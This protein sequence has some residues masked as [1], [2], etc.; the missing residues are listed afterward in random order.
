MA[1][2][3]PTMPASLMPGQTTRGDA[4]DER[5]VGPEE[6]PKAVSL[7]EGTHQYYRQPDGR[8]KLALIG[9]LRDG[10]GTAERAYR[11]R[12]WEPL[13]QYGRY[14]FGDWQ[15]EHPL[16]NLFIAG[17]ARELTLAQIRE[18][19]WD[20]TPPTIPW[21]NLPE[22]AEHKAK[23]RSTLHT[24]GCFE[25]THAVVF[26]QLAG[27]TP[28]TV[29][30]CDFCERDDIPTAAARKQHMY[31]MHKDELAQVRMGERIATVLSQSTQ[32][33]M[34]ADPFGCQVCGEGFSSARKLT[35][36]VRKHQEQNA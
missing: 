24:D 3:T 9:K 30:P 28:E 19:G 21:C 1:V 32:S 25:Q 17:G 4:I 10:E 29:D 14:C 18:Q 5:V 2:D 22:G 20:H 16:E 27:V 34:S 13:R 35:E 26:P 33:M 6:R 7:G 11:A 36:H 23:Y 8:I 31:T 12:G 15:L